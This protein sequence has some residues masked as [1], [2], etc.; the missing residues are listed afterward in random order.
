MLHIQLTPEVQQ[1]LQA[2][3]FEHT[4]HPAEW[5]DIGGPEN[6]PKLIGHNEFDEYSN[7]DTSVYVEDGIIVAVEKMQ[8]TPEGFP[9]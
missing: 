7:N 1:T 5:K 6:G 2:L 3:G 8:P 4:H 9:F